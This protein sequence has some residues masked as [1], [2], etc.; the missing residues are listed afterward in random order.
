VGASLPMVAVWGETNWAPD[1]RWSVRAGL[2]LEAGEALEN[3]GMLRASPRLS[4]RYTPE[5]EI[6][7]SAGYA[8]V[9]QYAQALAP[10]GVQMASLVSTD[11]WL[12]ASP[13]IPALRSDIVTA[14]LETSLAPGRVATINVFGRQTTG[15]ATPDPAPGPVFN[16]NLFVVGRSRA[17]GLEASVRQLAGPVTGSVSYTWSQSRTEASALTFASSSDRPHVLNATTMVRV[18]EPLRIGAAFT[19]ATGVPFTRTISDSIA[20]LEEPQCN[21]DA[22]PWAGDPN[23]QRAPLYA[24]LDLLVDYST[25]WAG[26]EVGIY[27]QLR[28]V[29]GRENAVVY[30]GT[31]TGCSV[32]GCSLDELRNA[33]EQGVPRLPVIGVRVRR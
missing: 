28:N 26:L 33:Y 8:R 30:T 7:F 5:P 15:M 25:R 19:A 17:Y 13:T 21:T 27:G 2:R 9:H 6:S 4:A 31:G 14:G 22:L 1:E 11:V 3:T 18:L 24:S 23:A 10:S 32:V 20:C 29:L 12:L 16:R